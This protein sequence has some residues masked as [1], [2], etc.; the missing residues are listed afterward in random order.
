MI[1][2]MLLNTMKLISDSSDFFIGMIDHRLWNYPGFSVMAEYEETEPHP[3]FHHNDLN[4]FL[5]AEAYPKVKSTRVSHLP[6]DY[7]IM[8]GC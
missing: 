5:N 8:W 7:Q 2:Y 1:I 6:Q 4:G 3:L